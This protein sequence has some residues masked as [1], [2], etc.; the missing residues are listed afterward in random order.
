MANV[1]VTMT[2][3][4]YLD[5]LRRRHAPDDANDCCAHAPYEC[6]FHRSPSFWCSHCTSRQLFPE[7]YIACP[8]PLPPRHSDFFGI[9]DQIAAAATTQCRQSRE[10]VAEQSSCPRVVSSAP[11]TPTPSR[12]EH[13][14]TR[15]YHSIQRPVCR[16]AVMYSCK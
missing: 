6:R 16:R 8:T 9:D 13:A 7:R 5:F 3:T 4:E 1:N 2:E 12:C 10:F 11:C 15:R 14:P